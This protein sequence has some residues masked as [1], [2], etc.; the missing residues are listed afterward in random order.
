MIQPML[1]RV[2]RSRRGVAIAM[3]LFFVTVVLF[4]FLIPMVFTRTERNKQNKLSLQYLKAHYL[5]QGAIQ[6]ALLK[7]R[8]LPT[9]IYSASCLQ[10]G[11]CPKD[12]LLT[13]TPPTGGRKSETAIDIFKDDITTT[14]FPIESTG[15]DYTGNNWIYEITEIKALTIHRR[16]TGSAGTSMS[17]HVLEILARATIEDDL[18]S[19]SGE[20]A[21]RSEM[22]KKVVEIERF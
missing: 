5:A 17:V 1:A 9:E 13:G 20:S 12:P 18:Y 2:R 16:Q 3:V 10:R 19:K 11:I 15:F 4:F 22:V 8:M 7:I 14:Q 21:R 6:H